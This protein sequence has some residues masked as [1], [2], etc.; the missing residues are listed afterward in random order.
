MCIHAKVVTMETMASFA[1]IKIGDISVY[2]DLWK[3]TYDIIE[4]RCHPGA[5][6]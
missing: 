4:E 2:D 1:N 3:I 5:V 6:L